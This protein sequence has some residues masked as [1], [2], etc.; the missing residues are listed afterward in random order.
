MKGV[1][2]FTRFPNRKKVM[3]FLCFLSLIFLSGSV[4]AVSAYNNLHLN[5]QVTYANGSIQ[6]GTFVF[7]FNISSSSDCASVVYSNSTTLTTDSRGIISY[8]LQNISLSDYSAQYWLCY[9]RDGILSDTSELAKVPYSFYASYVPSSGILANGNIDITGYNLT[10]GYLFGNGQYLTGIN[11]TSFGGLSGL[12]NYGYIPMWNG[13]TS[14]N[15]SNIF[16]L[17]N[18]VGIGT[19]SPAT[20]LQVVS[21]GNVAGAGGS[22]GIG[23]NTGVNPMFSI[24]GSLVGN[25]ASGDYGDV[26]FNTRP[27]GVSD[28]TARMTIKANGFVGIGT[29]TPQ[30]TLNV[31][32]D[33]NV[34]GTIYGV[35]TVLTNSTSSDTSWATNGTNIWNTTAK[36]GIGT[37]TPGYKL[38]INGGGGGTGAVVNVLRITGG[39]MTSTN[40]TTG[41][42][43]VQRE[44][45]DDY[46][47]FIRLVTTTPSPDYLNPRLDFGV[48]NP[49]TNLQANIGTKMSIL[50]S[51]NVG[52][53][54][55]SPK[56]LLSL[57]TANTAYDTTANVL[58]INNSNA[59]GQSP[60]DFYYGGN[61]GA[62]LR[63]DYVGNLNFIT[64]NL[65]VGGGNY[66]F[67]TGGDASPGTGTVKMAILNNGNVGIGTISPQA[68]LDINT[69]SIST[70]VIIESNSTQGGGYTP[71]L[72]LIDTFSNP[73]SSA[74]VWY[75]DNL[76]TNFR[77]FTQPNI[78]T[79]GTVDFFING[80]SG[81]VGIGT[82]SPS[83]KL[84][85]NGNITASGGRVYDKSGLV[86]PVG[87]IIAYGGSTAPNGWFLADGSAV[88]RTTY[89]DLFAIISTTY[90][91]GDGSTTFNLPDLRGI[92]PR[93]AGTNGKV[94]GTA[95]LGTYQSNSTARPATAFTTGASSTGTGT[96]GGGTTGGGT[97]GTESAAHTHTVPYASGIG[98]NYISVSL[99]ATTQGTIVTGTESATHTHSIPGLSIPGLSVPALSIPS[100]SVTGG[101]DSE[102]RPANVGVTYIIK[103]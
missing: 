99:F 15:N 60:I 14:Q 40:D 92:F 21:G 37:A 50:G 17:G 42:L 51:G 69:S 77:I 6:A 59:A 4:L 71:R 58:I 36:V 79:G 34:T 11:L 62:R 9:Y 12:G 33:L 5:L 1:H 46:G 39:Q 54:T 30:N 78:G 57:Q 81:N 44:I 20:T 56:G 93:G 75:M 84:D 31:K 65:T 87:S 18:N 45:Q 13:T 91:T 8:Y 67:F 64:N 70:G 22:I 49:S 47:A 25:G 66:Y 63:G 35:S 97:T 3:I 10:A 61:L 100:L 96:T 26:Y 76:A 72:G 24:N 53:G 85:V 19:T 102:T 94:S 55:T 48:Q 27:N 83:Q 86:M 23:A 80:T 41:L 74:L 52:I 32:G 16:Q 29:T 82:T 68:K 7:V 98:S 103:Y 73:A 95:T 38:S 101:G 43:F 88:S 90:G 2:K 28:L 89:A